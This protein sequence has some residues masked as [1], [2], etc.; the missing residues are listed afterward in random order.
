MKL[1]T[2]QASDYFQH[3]KPDATG[4][5]IYGA[6]AMRV[7]LKRQQVIKTL[8]GPKGD[9]EMRLTRIPAADLRKNPA[10]LVD[11]I[12]AI[13]FFPGPRVVFVEDATDAAAPTLKSALSDWQPDDAQVIVTA[14]QLNARSALRKLF[15]GHQNAYA[16]AIYDDPPS[17]AEI[18]AELKRAGVSEV[19]G[20]A[21]QLLETLSRSIDPGDL[22][23]VVEKLG[24]YKRG[25]PSPI[26]PE[27]VE[28]V[29]PLSTEAE[30]DDVLNIVAEGRT[31]ELGPVLARLA[32]QGVQPVGLCIGATRHFRALHTAAADPGG[33]SAGIAR[34]RPPIFGPRRDRML[35]QAQSWGMFK[36]EQA[37]Q[38]LTDT[39]LTL[40]SSSHAPAMAL[41]ERA[42]LRIATL[43]A[44]R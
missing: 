17:R 16:A 12:K 7:A 2:R 26:A 32:S 24:L 5:L 20:D 36:L 21:M 31:G 8:V 3:P 29:A 23:Q 14:K 34:L 19:S 35:R 6:D 44:R 41:T 27:D 37:L 33:P 43:G 4:L 25:D 38:I 22:R 40:R 30:L 15:E 42:F 13:S 9:E 10:A 18:E 11:A 1:N 39:D 28:A